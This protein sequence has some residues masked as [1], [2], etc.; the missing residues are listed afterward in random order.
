[1][2][3]RIDEADRDLSLSRTDAMKQLVADLYSHIFLF[4]NGVMDW[5]LEKRSRRLLDSFNDNFNDRFEEEI[6]KI[7]Q[8]AERVRM[9]ASQSS[10]A[11]IRVTRL[12]A[13]E[14]SRDVRL[15][16]DGQERIEAE[17]KVR[18]DRMEKQVSKMEDDR[19]HQYDSMRLLGDAVMALLKADAMRWFTSQNANGPIPTVMDRS[20][21]VCASGILCEYICGLQ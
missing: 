21:A 9:F 20:S 16:L 6:S 2:G 17:M 4:L 14:L 13:E 12:I 3:E 19:C 18:W 8:K 10:R 7:N 15:G 5:I 1:M 11:E